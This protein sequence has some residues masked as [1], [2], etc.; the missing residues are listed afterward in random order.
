VRKHSSRA[1]LLHASRRTS[2][3]ALLGVLVVTLTFGCYSGDD[4]PSGTPV[5]ECPEQERQPLI[6]GSTDEVFL[7]LSV[8]RQRAVVPLVDGSG[9]TDALCSGT[10]VAPTWVLSAAHCFQIPALVVRVPGDSSSEPNTLTPRRTELHATLDLM[11]LELDFGSLEDVDD[12]LDLDVTPIPVVATEPS[13]Q[14]GDA[15]ELAGYGT[16]E[17][18][19]VGELRF[20]VEPIVAVDETSI[21]VDGFGRTGACTGDSGGPMLT[22]SA[23]GEVVVLGVLSTGA[24]SCVNKDRFVRT[25]LARDWIEGL[26]GPTESIE[27]DCDGVDA[28]GRCFHDDALWCEDGRLLAAACTEIGKR[29]GWDGTARGFRCVDSASDPCRG[30]DGVGACAAGRALTCAAGSL[31]SETCGPCGDCFVDGRT[32]EPY[33]ASRLP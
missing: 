1:A 19:T 20:L 17:T 32:G 2:S 21:Q 27:P 6:G 29:C 11:L 12:V 25:A 23:I 14:P 13:I 24:A 15:V 31:L 22:R 3:D 30:V 8:S 10:F 33:C 4:D 5:A 9:K 26:I 28:G 16:T 7:G 18:S